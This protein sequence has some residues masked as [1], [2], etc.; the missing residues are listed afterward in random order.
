ME[1]P[2]AHMIFSKWDAISWRGSFVARGGQGYVY[3]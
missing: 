2:K 3:G 1:Q